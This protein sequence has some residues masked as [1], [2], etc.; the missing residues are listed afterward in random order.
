MDRV[1]NDDEAG[2][3]VIGATSI[4]W[5]LDKAFLRWNNMHKF[6]YAINNP[7]KISLYVKM[8]R[9]FMI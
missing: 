2:V 9:S 7:H 4:P 8:Q 3:V 6:T 1:Q 5:V